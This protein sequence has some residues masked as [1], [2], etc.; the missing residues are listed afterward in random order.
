MTKKGSSERKGN[1]AALFLEKEMDK[2]VASFLKG[3]K[4][5]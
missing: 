4:K 5:K 1:E 2:M 3:K